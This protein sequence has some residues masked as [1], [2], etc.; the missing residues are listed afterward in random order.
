MTF[1]VVFFEGC[2]AKYM[3]DGFFYIASPPFVS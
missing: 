1:S 3:R 2:G